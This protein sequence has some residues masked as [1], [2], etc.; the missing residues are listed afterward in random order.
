M[1]NK[2]RMNTQKID[3]DK[4]L[5]WADL[6]R[7]VSMAGIVLLHTSSCYWT[8][9]FVFSDKWTSMALYDS[10]VRWAL[11]IFVMISG[12]LFLGYKSSV[13]IKVLY[14]KYILRI[15]LAFI[16]WSSFYTFI[17]YAPALFRGES[18]LA[19]S[20]LK[21]FLGGY[22]H[23]WFLYMIA[24]LY[25]LVPFLRKIAAERSLCLYFVILN[26]I[27]GLLL[28]FVLNLASIK[29]VSLLDKTFFY[30]NLGFSGYFLWGYYL[31]KYSDEWNDSL[32]N[33][34]YAFGILCVVGTFLGT[35]LLSRYIGAAQNNFLNSLSPL[36][37]FTATAVF[38]AFKR[39]NQDILKK[40]AKLITGLSSLSFGIYLIHPFF[41]LIFKK[42]SLYSEITDNFF[43]SIPIC[44][45]LIFI[46]SSLSVF[47]IRKIKIVSKFV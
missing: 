9:Y 27:F 7:A 2:K 40:H 43:I 20:V 26:F 3:Q 1:Q 11:P 10:V 35:F 44:L 4:R 14:S 22:Y 8:D 23:L 41:I 42:L 33:V 6:L 34:F 31:D 15:A 17:S 45:V 18:I 32:V 5:L 36:H 16:V 19:T 37:F 21:S 38:L 28:P 25:M 24:G 12:M 39:M 29:Y 46:I 30:F 47:L 13:G